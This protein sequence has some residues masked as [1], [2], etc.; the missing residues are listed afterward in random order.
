V[1][2]WVRLAKVEDTDELAALLQANRAFLEPWEPSRADSWFTAD[3][4]Q[5]RLT[6]SLARNADGLEYP[7]MIMVDDRIAGRVNL[8][9]IVHGAVRS[10]DLGYW[11]GQ[12]DTG[13]GVATAA[14][15]HMLKVAFDKLRLHRV[16]A[17]TLLN[18]AA[19]Q[20]VLERNGFTR[21]GVAPNYL[22]IAGRWR[23]HLLFQRLAEPVA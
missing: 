10:A 3:N 15:G 1:T 17:G 20:R 18:N 14:V 21:I 9:N 23:D 8:N 11:V 19:S 16:Q 13:R 7:G 22:K 4:Q 12:A 5:E 2:V 6:E